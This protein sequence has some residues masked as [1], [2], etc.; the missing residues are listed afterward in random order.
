[1]ISAS[2]VFTAASTSFRW[3]SCSFCTSFSACFFSSSETCSVGPCGR[4][5]IRASRRPPPCPS[6]ASRFC[7]GLAARSR[8]SL[9]DGADALSGPHPGRRA[10]LV[11]V[12]PHDGE[13]VLLAQAEG[14]GVHHGVPLDQRVPEREGGEELRRRGF[15]GT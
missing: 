11:D 10:G 13:V 1:M 7:C 9:D 12:E 5:G 15:L 2:L 3:S 8:S 4:W 6:A 14:V